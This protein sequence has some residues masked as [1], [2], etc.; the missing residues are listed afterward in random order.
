MTSSSDRAAEVVREQIV[1]GIFRP[2][3]R[4]PEE[5]IADALGISRNTLREALSQLVA[6]RI[7]E[8]IPHR[9]VF[10]RV[11]TAEDVRDIYRARRV[12]EPGC[13]RALADTDGYDAS[14]VVDAV[15][16][17]EKALGAGDGDAVASANQR[18]HRA[19]VALGGSTRLDAEMS[20]L[21][22]EMRL[23]F[24]CA[25]EARDFHAPYVPMN[26]EIADLLAAGR[27][28]DAADTLARYLVVA[29]GDLLSAFDA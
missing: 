26:R 9:G 13:L 23:V 8:R 22:A 25:G 10:V 28:A 17:G 14:A 15:R 1:D 4:L 5:P 27:A 29:E 11:P 3:A 16:A 18:F 7:L 19:V 20:L 24:F 2:G 21:L 6:E 12:I